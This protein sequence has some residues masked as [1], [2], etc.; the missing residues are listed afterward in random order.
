MTAHVMTVDLSDP[1]PP[2]GTS[3]AVGAL[4]GGDRV[5]FLRLESGW[6]HAYGGGRHQ[7]CTYDLVRWWMPARVTGGPLLNPYRGAA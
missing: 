7:P 1:E 5:S 2:V 4:A 6:T 3:L